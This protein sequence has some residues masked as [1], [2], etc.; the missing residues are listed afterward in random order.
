MDAGIAI[1]KG[2]QSMARSTSP[3]RRPSV[4][5]TLNRASR[6]YLLITLLG[7]Q[8][9]DRDV[10]LKSLGVGLRTFYRELD[11]LKRCAIRID[12]DG[13]AYT[14]KTPKL[15]AQGR[16]PFPDPQLTFAEMTQLAQPSTEAGI[17]LAALLASVI[18]PPPSKKKPRGAKP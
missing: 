10:L 11:L 18:A 15:E 2:E 17:R 16:L 7:D 14:L 8:P 5:I 3:R 4:N 9:R 6:L 1:E 12:R 13:R